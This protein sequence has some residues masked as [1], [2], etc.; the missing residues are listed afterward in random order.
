MGSYAYGVS[1]DNSDTDVY[2]FCIPPIEIVFPHVRGVIQGFGDQG[3]KFDQFQQHH[4]KDEENGK[5]YDLSI[6]NIVKYFQLCMGCNP[7]MIDSLF[8]PK[9]AVIY[10]SKVAELVRENR[11][12]FLSKKAWGTFRGYAFSQIQKLGN[13]R[14]TGHRIH[15]VERFGYDVKYAYH[16]VRLLDE[17]EQILRDGDIDITRDKVR[18]KEIRNGKWTESQ[19]IDFF[20]TKSNELDQVYES[21]TL[22]DE[23]DEPLIRNLLVSCLEEAYGSLDKVL[24]AATER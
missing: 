20:R 17:A 11:K 4:V 16:L 15:L 18:L 5:E 7:N 21:S 13:K 9:E 2:G 3:E 6:Y 8:T 23:P 12:L 24:G 14:P 1:Q 22:Q 19:V 10:Q